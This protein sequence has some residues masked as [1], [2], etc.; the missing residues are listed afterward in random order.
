[1]KRFVFVTVASLLLFCALIS[2]GVHA[3]NTGFQTEEIPLKERI[4]LR[5]SVKLIEEEPKRTAIECFDVNE[6]GTIALCTR[7]ICGTMIEYTVRIY[8]SEGD[9]QYGLQLE[10]QGAIQIEWEGYERINIYYVRGGDLVTF[11]STGTK[12]EEKRVLNNIENGRFRRILASRERKVGEEEY[13][14]QKNMGLLG[15]FSPSCTQLIVKDAF[16]KER[17][18]YDVRTQQIIKIWIILTAISLFIFSICKKVF[19]NLL[20]RNTSVKQTPFF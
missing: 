20:N 11:D 13:S 6:E 19:E 16:G 12:L 8:N 17:V 18:L 10:N 4:N 7:R 1:M 9:F 14:I 3:M 15:L 2:P 5:Y